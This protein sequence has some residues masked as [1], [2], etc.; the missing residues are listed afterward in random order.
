MRRVGRSTDRTP[1]LRLDGSDLAVDVAADLTIRTFH[2]RHGRVTD[3]MR[4]VLDRIGPEHRLEARSDEDRPLVLE[5]GSGHG[6]AA[7]GFAI[8]HP[9]TD[10]LAVDVHTPGIVTLLQWAHD[11]AA[12]NVFAMRSDALELLE[13]VVRPASLAGVHLFFPDPWPKTKH[14]KRR[15]VRPDVLDL[16]ADR[17]APGSALR[18]ATDSDGYARAARRNLD[19]HPAF[20]GGPCERP[21]WRPVT[22]YEAAAIASGREVRD[23][24]YV[25]D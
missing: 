17:M 11:H 9:D 20:T 21:T 19:A 5:V 12:G 13:D 16:V 18:M 14:Q 2:G 7:I 15:F 8:A 6:E 24:E 4:R 1:S 3:R 25:R 23:L 10:I 22:R